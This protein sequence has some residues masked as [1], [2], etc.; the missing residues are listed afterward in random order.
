M[1][2]T[3]LLIT[4]LILVIGII[5][6]IFAVQ[7]RELST[8]IEII[9]NQSDSKNVVSESPREDAR[10]R[11]YINQDL[12][13]ESPPK[14]LKHNYKY[15]TNERILVFYNNGKFASINCT[16]YKYKDKKMQLIPNSGFG[17]YKG[18]WKQNEDGTITTRSF[19][20]NSDK[21]AFFS[22]TD[23]N[24][25]IIEQIQAIRKKAKGDFANEF[26][27]NGRIFVTSPTIE[28]IS[29]LLLLPDNKE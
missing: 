19:L 20:A 15:S 28:G 23:K 4:I 27:L 24:K 11:I 22:E 29:K 12:I 9:D 21:L 6:T 5:V 13:W 2:K 14:V 7:K 10:K 17:V 26:E 3:K 18:N 8:Q 25:E 1:Q 16:I